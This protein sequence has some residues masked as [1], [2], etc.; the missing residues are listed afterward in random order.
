MYIED[1]IQHTEEQKIKRIK[2]EKKAS[3]IFNIILT[4]ILLLL[5]YGSVYFYGLNEFF[6]GLAA[7]FLIVTISTFVAIKIFDSKPYI[8]FFKKNFIAIIVASIV[9]TNFYF[10]IGGGPGFSDR[11]C[12][13]N[14]FACE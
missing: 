9:L 3:N 11:P 8:P 14:A 12:H 13:V 1:L 5:S 6:P 7:G 10:L 4:G 2:K